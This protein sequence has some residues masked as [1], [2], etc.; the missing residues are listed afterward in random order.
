[1]CYHFCINAIP[2]EVFCGGRHG[3]T[4]AGNRL[5]Y[6]AVGSAETYAVERSSSIGIKNYLCFYFIFVDG[7]Q[8][9]AYG[10]GK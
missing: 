3:I 5:V 8:S 4:S 2:R 6:D 7:S 9:S 10:S 1:M